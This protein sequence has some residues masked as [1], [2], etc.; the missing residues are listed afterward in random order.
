MVYPVGVTTYWYYFLWIIANTFASVYCTPTKLSFK[1][2]PYTAYLC[3][4][5]RGTQITHFHLMA[6]LTPWPK[7]EKNEETKPISESWYLRNAWCDF[8]TIWNVGYWWWRASLQQ[9]LSGFVKAAWRYIH[10]HEKCIHY[11]SFC[12]LSCQYT[13]GCGTPASLA[14][15]HTTVCLD[16][17]KCWTDWFIRV[18]LHFLTVVSDCS[19][20]VSWS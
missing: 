13:H 11:C 6:T 19:T 3:T 14:A 17:F 1:M 2:C 4:K 16:A 9:K 12:H 8:V 15:Q 20:R 10:I 5:F 18:H 7:E